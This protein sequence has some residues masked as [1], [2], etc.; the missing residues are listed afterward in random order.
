MTDYNAIA[1]FGSVGFYISD[2]TVN[3]TPSTLKTKIGKTFIKK[4][5]PFRDAVDINLTIK[6]VIGGL[7]DTIEN[8][9]AALI[10]LEDGDYHTYEDG[11]HSGNFAIEAGSLQW[12][13]I[14]NNEPGQK[15]PFTIKL[16]QWQ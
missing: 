3:R 16:I 14:A 15:K 12:D 7:S 6:G 13:D 9:R 2:I 11:R 1:N 5:I 8:E 4:N 10:A